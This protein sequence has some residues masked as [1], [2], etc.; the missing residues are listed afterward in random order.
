LNVAEEA[1]ANWRSLEKIF[2][3]R[4]RDKKKERSRKQ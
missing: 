3:M 4:D 1:L 2:T